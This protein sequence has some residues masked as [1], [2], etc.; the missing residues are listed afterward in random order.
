MPPF[1]SQGRQALHAPPT[2][3]SPTYPTLDLTNTSSVSNIRARGRSTRNI[4]PL[5]VDQEIRLSTTEASTTSKSV[6]LASMAKVSLAHTICARRRRR[7]Q[8]PLIVK[9]RRVDILK[10][11]PLR[12][13]HTA[14]FNIKRMARVAVEVV[15]YCV[16]QRVALSTYF[17]AAAGSVVDVVPLHGDE[18]AAAEEEDG[19]V[20]AAVARGRPGGRPV[21]FRVA[22]CYAT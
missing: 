2:H 1:N 14:S 3:P 10:N 6:K 17:G 12:N 5:E 15:V 11:I 20:V 7:K 19:P 4:L 13:N 8:L 21:E 16:E 9:Q 18:V 22:D